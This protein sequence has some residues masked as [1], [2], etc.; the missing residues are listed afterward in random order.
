MNELYWH[1]EI[2]K[3]VYI[4]CQQ[5]LKQSEKGNPLTSAEI[6]KDRKI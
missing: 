2:N 5:S 4:K 3:H 1:V 6:V